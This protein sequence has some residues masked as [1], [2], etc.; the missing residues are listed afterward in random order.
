MNKKNPYL[1]ALIILAYFLTTSI[2][3][4]VLGEILNQ[5]LNA[6][7]IGS[8]IGLIT[9]YIISWIGIF[10]YIKRFKK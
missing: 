3:G 6:R 7:P 4:T 2:L 5:V 9:F 1:L 10:I 8:I